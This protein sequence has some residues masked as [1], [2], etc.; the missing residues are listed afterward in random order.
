MS[1][2]KKRPADSNVMTEV[3]G[4]KKH[5]STH[6]PRFGVRNLTYDIPETLFRVL[7]L[8]CAD[9]TDAKQIREAMNRFPQQLQQLIDEYVG[10]IHPMH[11][12][13]WIYHHC[14]YCG[15]KQNLCTVMM[16][17]RFWWF[18]CTEHE[19]L[20]M[21]DHRL[22]L[23]ESKMVAQER[24]AA[25]P[26]LDALP[27]KF[28]VKRSSGELQPGWKLFDG[29]G[30][31]AVFSM[32]SKEWILPCQYDIDSTYKGVTVESLAE[33]NIDQKDRQLWIDNTIAYLNNCIQ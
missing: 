6:T 12:L 31:P 7:K 3:G 5:K 22:Y 25:C 20:A 14:M 27:D 11:T 15:N 4:D 24:V 26:T 21:R 18:A 1:G 9:D 8:V 33:F 23:R 10:V 29:D 17:Y 30:K 16:Q 2:T 28:L 19:C 13:P 32:K